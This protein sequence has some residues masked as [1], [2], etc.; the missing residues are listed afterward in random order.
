MKWK[1]FESKVIEYVE[2][3][4][5]CSRKNIYDA[6]YD[7]KYGERKIFS[8]N[9]GTVIS[10]L[11]SK[12]KLNELNIKRKNKNIISS[13]LIIPTIKKEKNK[14][15]PDKIKKKR[16]RPKKG[17]TNDKYIKTMEIS[18][19]KPNLKEIEK[20]ILETL[21]YPKSIS[22]LEVELDEGYQIIFNILSRLRSRGVA[23]QD[24]ETKKWSLTQLGGKIRREELLDQKDKLEK[25]NFYL[26]LPF[27][28]KPYE[29]VSVADI[30]ERAHGFLGHY[31]RQGISDEI[32]EED[33]F[34]KVYR[35]LTSPNVSA[36]IKRVRFKKWE[37]ICSEETLYLWR[38]ESLIKTVLYK[39]TEKK[40]G[41][42]V[43]LYDKLINLLRRE[44]NQID[45][46]IKDLSEENQYVIWLMLNGVQLETILPPYEIITK[47]GHSIKDAI[48]KKGF[49]LNTYNENSEEETTLIEEETSHN[50][51]SFNS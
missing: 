28:V 1:P 46:N 10:R 23:I 18:S 42:G 15:Q 40:I 4:P 48:K 17:I 8:K 31:Y 3:N 33:L 12:D 11:V 16:G 51:S 30:V 38:L 22:E 21:N 20:R 49:P 24:S 45:E 35:H 7:K 5:N 13:S 9:I 27:L 34:N 32:A 44:F 37:V 6:L 50:S 39:S 2:K 43:D 25:D 47:T 36:F 19:I 41:I 29:K 26:H 14:N